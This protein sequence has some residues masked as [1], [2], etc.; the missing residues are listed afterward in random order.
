[1]SESVVR[2]EVPTL[3]TMKIATLYLLPASY[4]FIP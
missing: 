2:F 3:E 4:W 1:V